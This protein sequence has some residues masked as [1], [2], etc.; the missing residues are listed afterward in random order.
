MASPFSYALTHLLLILT[1]ILLAGTACSPEGAQNFNPGVERGEVMQL[2][3]DRKY[4]QAVWILES[5]LTKS[6]DDPEIRTRLAEAHL[7]KAGFEL[8]SIS[9]SVLF[10][11][12]TIRN[13]RLFDHCGTEV[14]ASLDTPDTRCL[15]E[16]VFQRVPEADHPSM[17][18]ARE[19]LRSTYPDPRLTQPS[20]NT[21][22][23][24]VELSSAV[25]RAA[26]VALTAR[27]IPERETQVSKDKL[28]K[29]LRQVDA[30]L[31][32]TREA[33]RRAEQ[34]Q[35]TIVRIVTGLRSNDSLYRQLE[36]FIELSERLD[37]PAL[38]RRAQLA[39]HFIE[40][41]PHTRKIL[42]ELREFASQQERN[43]GD[44][45]PE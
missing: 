43:P 23:G 20:M 32:E 38:L 19:L 17:A 18:R 12:E 41:D 25:Y 11:G 34:S 39:S 15:A 9:S 27:G 16:R 40:V 5:R 10:A 45:Q 13:E 22:I 29:L 33:V 26:D 35:D 8:L 36:R 30:S 2:L 24:A 14:W 37:L 42:K 44:G 28:V 4:D 6:P 7:G 3:N 31:V 21:L 1:A